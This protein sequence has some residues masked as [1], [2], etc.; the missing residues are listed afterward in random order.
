MDNRISGKFVVSGTHLF[1]VDT[2][3]NLEDLITGS[4]GHVK[5]G[6][7]LE[8]VVT[9]KTST[10]DRPWT[11]CQELG[12]YSDSKCEELVA[13]STV[14][15]AAHFH[16]PN[17]LGDGPDAQCATCLE[18][19]VTPSRRQDESPSYNHRNTEAA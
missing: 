3:A 14:C 2:K 19:G 13:P 5:S 15:R 10:T 11:T 8:V 17:W 6:Q 7:V 9:V 18:W 4:L 16:R 12:Y 1:E